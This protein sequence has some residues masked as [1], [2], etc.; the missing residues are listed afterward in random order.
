[1]TKGGYLLKE[2]L[3]YYMNKVKVKTMGSL[4]KD[5]LYGNYLLEFIINLGFS[6]GA[7]G[8]SIAVCKYSVVTVK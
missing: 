4:S 6:V 3:L 8:C 2:G 5:G 1:M 7:T